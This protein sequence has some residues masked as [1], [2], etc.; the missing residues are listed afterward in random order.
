[1]LERLSND[2]AK[3]RIIFGICKFF[4]SFCQEKW[5]NHIFEALN[6]QNG[7]KNPSL[8][9][10]KGRKSGA[11]TPKRG[12]IKARDKIPNQWSKLTDIGA[13]IVTPRRRTLPCVPSP[14]RAPCAEMHC[15]YGV[16][17]SAER[18]GKRALLAI[19]TIRRKNLRGAGSV[20]EI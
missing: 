4:G 15:R 13:A 16:L 19:G 17:S 9:R 14:L 11:Y 20:S 8:R 5:K 18:R 10:N 7:H 2:D 6:S 1:M 3:V 12:R